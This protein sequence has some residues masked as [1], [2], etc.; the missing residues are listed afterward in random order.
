[1]FH[2]GIFGFVRCQKLHM[3]DLMFHS[4]IDSTNGYSK[5]L[6][7]SES[8][9]NEGTKARF[10]GS[11]FPATGWTRMDIIE[12]YIPNCPKVQWWDE[13]PSHEGLFWFQARLRFACIGMICFAF[14]LT[15]LIAGLWLFGLLG[16]IQR[17][18]FHALPVEWGERS[19]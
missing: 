17:A 12:G 1:M 8:I 9:R 6:F 18:Q 19:N 14:L 10:F 3:N 4:L 5:C 15:L 2:V 7:G 13:P 16:G 11:N